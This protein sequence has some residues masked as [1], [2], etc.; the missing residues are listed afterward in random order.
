MPQIQIID[1]TN[2]DGE[3]T[4]R[5]SLAKIQKTVINWLL[6]QMG[7]YQSEMGFPLSPHE[8]NYI[9]A[10]YELMEPGPNGQEPLMKHIQL[11][12][13]SR[14][15]ATDVE[16]AFQQTKIKHFNLSI[17]TSE[18]MLRWKFREKFSEEDILKMV[19]DATQAAKAGGAI[20]A[21][22]NAEDASRTSLD[23]LIRFAQ[24]GKE[25][26][27]DRFRYCDTLGH[28][29]P[30]TISER[31]GTIA[32]EVEIPI[33]LHCHNDLGLAV[34]NSC[35][36][37]IAACEA[38]QDAYI[39]TTVN[40]IG[41][42]AGNA[43]LVSCILA[44][45]YASRWGKTNLL[46]NQIDL[47]KAWKIARYVAHAFGLEI[48]INQP[49]VGANAFAHESG[50]HADGALKDRHNYELYDYEVLGRGERQALPT[51]RVITTG[52]HGGA[53]GLEYVYAQMDL[54][55]RD[56]EHAREI[57]YLVQCANLSTQAPLTEEELWLIYHY[58]D[59]VRKLL[60]LTP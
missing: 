26:G 13:W 32:R 24:A 27:A 17:S 50:I 1:V 3:Q 30:S 33:E 39:N 34:A 18:Q 2:R 15:L 46:S 21:G 25:A 35:A 45:R 19:T 59:Q 60:T 36:G 12:G 51:G 16:K 5:I 41:E 53:S 47:K 6:D 58:P 31:I 52:I 28:D 23:F 49:G 42:R 4:A 20:T 9:N 56:G 38:G 44:L 11:G 57:L 29:D 43:D 7:V 14:A 55:F 10:N 48:P 40:G 54:G 22:V 8:R 37:A